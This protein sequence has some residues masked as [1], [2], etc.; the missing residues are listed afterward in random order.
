[1]KPRRRGLGADPLDAI[2]PPPSPEP[3]PARR[4]KK[5]RVSFDLPPD[6]AARARNA[7]VALSGP[8]LRLNL[9]TLAQE[10]LLR[11]I[12]RLEREHNRGR[13]FPHVEEKL[14]GGRPIGS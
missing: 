9:S 13:P 5:E 2:V 14:R 6:L 1:M 12:E 4:P 8:P 3:P 7:A 10:G 11:E